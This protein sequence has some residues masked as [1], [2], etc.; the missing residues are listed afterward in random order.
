MWT[1]RRPFYSIQNVYELIRTL[2]KLK[3]G[4]LAQL[5][6]PEGVPASVWAILRD[7][8]KVEPQARP[9]TDMLLAGFE[10]LQ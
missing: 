4:Q 5:E 7:C 2:R 10:A 9:T 6:Q 3:S 8:L 1:L